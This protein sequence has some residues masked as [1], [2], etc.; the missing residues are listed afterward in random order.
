MEATVIDWDG[1]N[2]PSELRLLPPGRYV[3]AP[4]DD[5][6]E[7]SPQEEEAILEGLADLD[8]GRVVPF[9]QAISEIRSYSQTE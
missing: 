1:R 9:D 3:L 2:L 5:S 6:P 7:L 8:A 4:V